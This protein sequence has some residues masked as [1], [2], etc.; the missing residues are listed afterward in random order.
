MNFKTLDHHRLRNW[1]GEK[2]NESGSYVETD[3][4]EIKKG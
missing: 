2:V 1:I 4:P 3:H